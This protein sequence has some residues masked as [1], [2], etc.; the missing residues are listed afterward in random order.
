MNYQFEVLDKSI[1]YSGF[2][3]MEKYRLRHELFAG[4]WSGEMSRECLER[5]HAV[6][7]PVSYT[8]LAIRHPTLRP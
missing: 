3:R 8:H 4:G 1:C 5:G 2:F 7:V 6:A